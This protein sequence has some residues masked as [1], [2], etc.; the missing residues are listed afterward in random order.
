MSDF[1]TMQKNSAIDPTIEAKV[2]DLSKPGNEGELNKAL[3]DEFKQIE[4]PAQND[5]QPVDDDP[6]DPASDP[7]PK[8]PDPAADPEGDNDPDPKDPKDPAIDPKQ[9][10]AD[11]IKKI[12]ADKNAATDAAAQAELDK[13]ADAKKIA[14]LEA[15]NASLRTGDKGE[16]DDPSD[17]ST[18]KNKGKSI[19]QIVKEKVDDAL[20]KADKANAA[21]KSNV[22]EVDALKA[23]DFPHA[24][25]HK[26]T[27]TQAMSRFN[28]NAEQAYAYLKGQDVIPADSA[29]ASNANKLNTGDQPKNNLVKDVKPTE[30]STKE[31]EAYLQ[32][33]QAAG[34]LA[35]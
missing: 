28:M 20:G 25:E 31:Q 10:K 6:K 7:D 13:A 32:K 24:V 33:E 11:K 30:M 12:L 15:E 29:P 1:D 14:D 16:G 3:N 35:L 8:D 27:I 5:P 21:E 23:D 19:D 9:A 2:D 26:D 17:P 4:D 34:R 22:A 18:D